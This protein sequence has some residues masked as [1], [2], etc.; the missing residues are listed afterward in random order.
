MEQTVVAPD[1]EVTRENARDLSIQATLL[2][3]PAAA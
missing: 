1:Y 2:F 3:D